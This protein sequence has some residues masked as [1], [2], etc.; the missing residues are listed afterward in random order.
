MCRHT[1]LH[2]ITV[3]EDRHFK[4]ILLDRGKDYN[5]NLCRRRPS[6]IPE[7]LR[8]SGQ[9]KTLRHQHSTQENIESLRSYYRQCE[10]LC[11]CVWSPILQLS[12]CLCMTADWQQSSSIHAGQ[13]V[14]IEVDDDLYHKFVNS[15]HNLNEV[16]IVVDLLWW[17]WLWP[18]WTTRFVL[19]LCYI[20]SR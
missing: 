4:K 14:L 1:V 7:S 15:N 18:K 10:S 9:R 12:L 5:D 8:S 17:L 3:V 16:M 19:M 11:V 13:V 2:I 6:P 20:H